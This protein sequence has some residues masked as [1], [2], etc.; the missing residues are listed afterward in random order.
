M[1]AAE[2][3]WN[4]FYCYQDL[5]LRVR[6]VFTVGHANPLHFHLSS[7]HYFLSSDLEDLLFTRRRLI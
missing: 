2:L 3:Y 4:A 7:A 1:M 5:E 6:Q